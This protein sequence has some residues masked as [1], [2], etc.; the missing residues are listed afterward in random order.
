MKYFFAIDGIVLRNEKGIEVKPEDVD[1]KPGGDIEKI[2]ED[3]A[4]DEFWQMIDNAMSMSGL[5]MK[6]NGMGVQL[7]YTE[8]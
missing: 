1:V 4:Q 6:D 7:E 2:M 8:E 5:R 3:V